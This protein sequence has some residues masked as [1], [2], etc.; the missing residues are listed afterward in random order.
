MKKASAWLVAF[1]IML[2]MAAWASGSNPQ[3]KSVLAA[4][5]AFRAGDRSAL[6]RQTEK[7]RGHVLEVYVRFWGLKLR[8][9]E[10]A[11]E[12]LRAFLA[13]NQ[14][15]LLAEQLRK[16]WLRTLGKNG[17][18][19][20]FRE[21]YPA[22]ANG[23]AEIACYALQAQ[24]R[25]Q[26][27]TAAEGIKPFWN[28]PK[29]LPQG[30]LP[31]AEAMLQS[32]AL[33]PRDLLVRF[34]L[35]V[36]SHQVTEALRVLERLPAERMPS[37]AVIG[38]VVKTPTAFLERSD[39]DLNSAAERELAICALVHQSHDDPRLAVRY[40][41]ALP[42]D[43]F[44][45]EDRQYLW[46]Q[47]AAQGALRHIPESLDWF[48][49]AG[50]MPLSE[51]QLLWRTRIALRQ[52]NWPEVKSAIERLSPAMQAE[53]TWTFWL[54]RSLA[55]LGAREEGRKLLVRI[56]GGHDFYG[57]LAAEELGMPL[58]LPPQ[59]APPSAKEVEAVAALPGLKRALAL[60]RLGLRNE[61]T[62]EWVWAVRSIDDRA[63]LAAAELARRNG[64]WDRAINTAEKTVAAHDFSVRYPQHYNDVLSQAARL[65]QLDES[66][67]FG[68][69]RQ[70]SRFLANAKSPAGATGLMQLL[71]ST[72]QW[73]AKKI[74]L[75]GFRPSSTNKPEV[76]AALG[77][78]YLR[79]VLD[80]LDGSPVL[81]AAAYNAGP[82]RARK[83]CDLKPLEGAIYIETI[84]FSETRQYVKKVMTNALY[85]AA[86]S[87]GEQ[88]SLKSTLGVI[89]GMMTGKDNVV[90]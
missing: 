20:L 12:E 2:P 67:V 35:L 28:A 45:R 38:D 85:Y 81:A 79:H 46:A 8:L 14:G 87:G 75:K 60:Y 17:Q 82:S 42:Q 52:E 62:R 90:Q 40:W 72:A 47:F 29:A 66:L 84:P 89:K 5:D 51:E 68:L 16:D 11:P 31:V 63:L 65:R 80:G 39:R 24:W 33:A 21:E 73:V 3:D 74:G 88:R 44:P 41:N 43:R 22:L 19:D 56:A 61:A 7:A 54:G 1:L 32:G 36:A 57:R 37:P 83:W 23:D 48:K 10:A 25:L 71:P 27:E 18:W 50:E 77:A 78:F 58:Q 26:N 6:A 4:F 70:E 69:V 9:E 34:R 30:C 13:A 53:T 76:N 49:E 59:E 64:I 15:T 86:L 55:A